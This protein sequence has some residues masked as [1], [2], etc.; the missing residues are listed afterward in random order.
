MSIYKH[1]VALAVIAALSPVSELRAQRRA[2]LP[3][4]RITPPPSAPAAP[5]PRPAPSPRVKPTSPSTAKPTVAKPS[6]ASRTTSTAP[7]RPTTALRP[8]AA[9]AVAGAAGSRPNAVAMRVSAADMADAKNRLAETRRRLLAMRRARDDK[10]KADAA[11]GQ[12][13]TSDGLAAAAAISSS[14]TASTAS[15]DGGVAVR[16]TPP[17]VGTG[18][19]SSARRTGLIQEFKATDRSGLLAANGQRVV[20]TGTVTSVERIYLNGVGMRLYLDGS[21]DAYVVIMPVIFDAVDKKLGGG[22]VIGKT[23][24]VRLNPL[25]V[26]EN[27]PF[28]LAPSRPENIELVTR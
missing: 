7:R 10:E 13:N 22:A 8:R 21:K 27:G 16:A 9:Q 3:P 6:T 19:L 18:G 2:P 4:P 26:V 20:I 28:E 15:S 11:R 24:A 14:G 1:L 17:A 5:R 23:I 25:F 12:R